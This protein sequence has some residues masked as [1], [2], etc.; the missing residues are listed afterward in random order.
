MAWGTCEDLVGAEFVPFYTMWVP[1]VPSPAE[2]PCRPQSSHFLPWQQKKEKF[3]EKEDLSKT[4]ALESKHL[5]NTVRAGDSELQWWR[6][7]R[8]L[9]ADL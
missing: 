5:S 4:A 8:R 9:L 6:P 3:K 7:G 2:P 1:Q